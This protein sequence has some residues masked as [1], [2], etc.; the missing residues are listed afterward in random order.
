LAGDLGANRPFF[1]AL[2]HAGAPARGGAWGSALF[3]A[4]FDPT[5]MVNQRSFD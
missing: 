4:I 1:I 3:L 5:L 2:S